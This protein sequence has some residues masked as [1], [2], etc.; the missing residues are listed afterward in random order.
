MPPRNKIV[1]ST[2]KNTTI[3]SLKEMI[4]IE[5]ERRKL[6]NKYI[7]DN[8]KDGVD[9]GRIHIAKNCDY[10]Y[11]TSKCKQ[12]SHWSKKS[13]FKPGSEKFC[14]LMYLRPVFKKDVET[15]EMA[16]SP[17]G[18]FCYVC[19]LVDK[20]GAIVGEGR[21]AASISEKNWTPNNAIKIA[22]KR[23]QID[24]IL[25]TGTLS[26]QFTQ[27]LEDMANSEVVAPKSTVKNDN[28][29]YAGKATEK[30]VK[31]IYSLLSAKGKD[32]ET[33]FK[34]MKIK[35]MND[36]SFQSASIIIKKLTGLP[37]VDK[38]TDQEQKKEDAKKEDDFITGLEKDKERGYQTTKEPEKK[39][40]QKPRPTVAANYEIGWVRAHFSD[41]VK[42]GLFLEGQKDMVDF[43]TKQEV[44]ELK[45]KYSQKT[46]GGD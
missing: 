34:H 5:T 30:Q 44:D 2:A 24:A 38:E 42:M 7:A 25:R 11:E 39:E 36:L 17:A 45:I 16:G 28:H 46:K 32:K 21:G 35:S 29:A 3:S 10:K 43:L 23:A 40:I 9:Y 1:K 8:L 41:L 22:E 27:D 13:L 37:S 20:K 18:L 33:I 14:S 12:D 15:Y 31:Y 19:E 4:E 6:L 26:D